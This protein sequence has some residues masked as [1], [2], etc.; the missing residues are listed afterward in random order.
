MAENDILHYLSKSHQR[1]NYGSMFVYDNSPEIVNKEWFPAL[2]A[3]Q[4]MEKIINN[5]IK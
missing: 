3:L 4:G 5:D 2:I 1:R